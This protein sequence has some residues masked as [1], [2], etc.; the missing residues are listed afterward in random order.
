MFMRLF[1]LLEE[2]VLCNAIPYAVEIRFQFSCPTFD[3]APV[4]SAASTGSKYFS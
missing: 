4:H 3:F 1:L 2:I